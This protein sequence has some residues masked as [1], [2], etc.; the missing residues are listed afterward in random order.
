MRQSRHHSTAARVSAFGRWQMR[1]N[2]P[3][4]T[5][6]LICKKQIT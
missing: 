2:E 4:L 6:W 3:R 1:I 5:D